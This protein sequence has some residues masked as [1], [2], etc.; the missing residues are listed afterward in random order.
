MRII[1]IGFEEID[2][3]GLAD[4]VTAGRKMSN[5][6]STSTIARYEARGPRGGNWTLALEVE[7]P[8]FFLLF[9]DSAPKS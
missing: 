4:R 9:A 6:L 3:I 2:C 1:L 5:T 8:V 7:S